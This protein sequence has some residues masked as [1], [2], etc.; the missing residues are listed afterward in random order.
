VR[1]ARLKQNALTVG[2]V[3]SVLFCRSQSAHRHQHVLF[4]HDKV[5]GVEGGEFEAVSVSDGVCWTGLNAIA[6]KDAAVVIDVVHLGVALGR[7][8]S[9]LLSVLSGLNVNAICRT[10]GGAEEAGYTLLQ[11]VLVALQ[12]MRAA[13]A[14]LE[15]SSAHRARP[16]RV[17]LY[18]RG[19]EHLA[20]GDAHAFRDGGQVAHNRH[21]HSIRWISRG[22]MM[23]IKVRGFVLILATGLAPALAYS[24][25]Q[26]SM[27]G[28]P[29]GGNPVP[30]DTRRVQQEMAL[31]K[32][33]NG[34]LKITFGKKSAEWTAAKLAALP[35]QTITVY[36]EHA[37][38]NQTYSGV[39][40]IDLMTP[41]GVPDKPRGKEFR[42]Y[43]VA[44][45]A[46]GYQVVFSA[47]EATPDVHDATLIV[48]DAMDG[49]PLG[50]NGPLQLVATG[51]KRP[52]RWVRNLI[53]I[54]VMTAD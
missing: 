17:V 26:G 4:A 33:A 30:P 54:R 22:L 27:Q 50:I 41:L 24:Q 32:A 46:D 42:L 38:A 7:R 14:L 48:A 6:A 25:S 3:G 36:N 37:K 35:H 44:E 51:E 29:M 8:D 19:L 49:K 47:A 5:G 13:I 52:A 45:G 39:Q 31:Q 1:I 23:R 18:L 16:V 12:H 2:E 20:E 34:P 40:V 11:A 28:L 53:S 9:I 43:L 15:N 10:G 21:R